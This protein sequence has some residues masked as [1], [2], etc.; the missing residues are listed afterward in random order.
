MNG[1]VCFYNQKRIEVHSASTFAAQ[2]EAARLL[3]VPAK[4][5]Y[6]ISVT[7]AEKDGQPVTH[8]PD[9]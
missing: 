5:Q 8:T 3:K 9:F 7:L 6:M 4:K 2:Q 1:Y